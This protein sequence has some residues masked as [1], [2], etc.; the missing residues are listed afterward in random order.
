MFNSLGK[1]SPG[2]IRKMVGSQIQALKGRVE[3]KSVSKG[4]SADICEAG[5][6]QPDAIHGV[7]LACRI[8]KLR[9]AQSRCEISLK[10]CHY[11]VVNDCP[12]EGSATRIRKATI[13]T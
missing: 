12:C 6:G 4:S 11:I 9:R 8:S 3:F 7:K 10:I 1:R 2:R 13:A 5:V